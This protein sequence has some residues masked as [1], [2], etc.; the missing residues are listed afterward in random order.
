MLKAAAAAGI[1]WTAPVVHPIAAHAQAQGCTAEQFD[2]NGTAVTTTSGLAD[3]DSG[4]AGC[5]PV[6]QAL[7]SICN[8]GSWPVG[9]GPSGGTMTTDVNGTWTYTA[10]A[11]CTIVDATGRA[12]DPNQSGCDFQFKCYTT[13]T[14]PAVTINDGTVVFPAPD[15][16]YDYVVF[17]VLLCCS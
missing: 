2:G 4:C 7:S 9:V 6:G 15:T 8:C 16:G 5:E 14:S 1:V 10:P 11:G 13:A 17:R 3:L 12:Y